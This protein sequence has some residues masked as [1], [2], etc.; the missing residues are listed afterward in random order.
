MR[1]TMDTISQQIRASEGLRGTDLANL[2]EEEVVKRG[3]FAMN[4][5]QDFFA[6]LSRNGNRFAFL[7]TIGFNVSSAVVNLSQVP[8]IV[9]PFMVGRTDAKTATTAL[10]NPESFCRR[11]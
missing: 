10:N 4:P 11:R 5:P 7:G 9:Y 3:N 1:K 6:R 8:L 2:L